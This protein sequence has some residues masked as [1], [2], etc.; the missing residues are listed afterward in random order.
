M[1]VEL[2][3]TPIDGLSMEDTV[4]RARNAMKERSPIV[5]V[6]INVAKL[7]DMRSDPE[8]RQDVLSSDII[9]ADGMGVVMASRLIGL[10]LRNRVAGIDLMTALLALCA[11]EGFRPYF[12]GASQEVVRRA[13]AA[14]VER[15]P[16]L[17]VAG[18]HCGYFGPEHEAAIIDEIRAADPDC[19][20]VGMPTPRKERFIRRQRGALHVPFVMGV[21]GSF[22]ILA[23]DVRR[24]PGWM[25]A[26]GLEWAYRVYQEPRRMWWRYART[27]AVF[28]WLL[29]RA[30]MRSKLRLDGD[31]VFR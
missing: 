19:L 30:L 4:S 18:T 11:R 25:Q 20:F 1:R 27:N 5:Q 2:L 17:C 15:F 24:A 6:S 7:V 23:G 21:G 12:L 22:D 26:S 29:L 28:G 8:L 16:G 3:G 14:A 31:R 10:E 9:S 13:A